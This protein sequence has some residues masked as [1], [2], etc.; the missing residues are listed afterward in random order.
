MLIYGAGS[1]LTTEGAT[2]LPGPA[3]AVEGSRLQRRAEAAHPDPAVRRRILAPDNLR[4]HH[5]LLD[6]ADPGRDADRLAA[7][8]RPQHPNGNNQ[9][10]YNDPELVKLIE[11]ANSS[12][13]PAVQKKNYWKAQEIV[14]KDTAAVVGVYTQETSLAIDP[15]LK[16]VWLEAAQGEP[17]VLRRLLRRR[18]GMGTFA[19][20]QGRRRSA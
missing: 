18:I 14:T 3:G 12:D 17:V 5:R 4:R 1:I 13:D 7:L 19:E 9:S 11:T 10:F 16:D 15:K 2:L 20:T 8:G 6:L